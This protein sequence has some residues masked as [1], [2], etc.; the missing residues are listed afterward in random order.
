M[1]QVADWLE[2]LGMSEY[3]QRFAENGIS[4]AALRYLTDQDLK[5]MGGPARAQADNAGG[6]QRTWQPCHGNAHGCRTRRA[7]ATRHNRT[8]RAS[9]EPAAEFGLPARE[10]M[11][12][13]RYLTV[14]FCDLVGSTG[15]SAQLDAED[16]RDLVGVYVDTASAAVTE[17]GGHVAKKLGDGL[18]A[19]FGY[20]A[21]QENHRP[22]PQPLPLPMQRHALRIRAPF[23]SC[24]AVSETPFRTRNAVTPPDRSPPRPVRSAPVG[25]AHDA[26][27]HD[28]LLNRHDF[29]SLVGQNR[30]RMVQ[31]PRTT[32]SPA[33]SRR[34][35]NIDLNFQKRSRMSFS[36]PRQHT[37]A[38]K[39][40]I[41]RFGTITN[42]RE[43]LVAT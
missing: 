34:S 8:C 35:T 6:H 31:T 20:P 27:H 15:L 30:Q 4:A 7:E 40:K 11:G 1:Q 17:M 36:P 13:R 42:Q 18:M 16:W 9:A 3:A 39:P 14:L 2:K 23:Q 22:L 38:L 25:R 21:A 33:G 37:L 10:A 29:D 41:K 19:L 43:D 28:L 5:E 12:E 24:N 26:P 32:F